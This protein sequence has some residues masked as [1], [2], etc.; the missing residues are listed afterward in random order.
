[1]LRSFFWGNKIFALF[2]GIFVFYDG[3]KWGNFVIFEVILFLFRANLILTNKNL[4][5]INYKD[6]K[7]LKFFY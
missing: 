6:V 2:E 3:K 5:K 4:D 1:M 7:K